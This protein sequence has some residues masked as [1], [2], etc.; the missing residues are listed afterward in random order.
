MLE[1]LTADDS[2]LQKIIFS[3][4]TIF[5]THTHTWSCKLSQLQDLRQ[6]EPI[7]FNPLPPTSV[8]LTSPT[9]SRMLLT[10]VCGTNLRALH[11]KLPYKHVC[12]FFSES[13]YVVL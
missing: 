12:A 6:R 3:D 2:Y 1:Q 4:K 8:Q 13:N 11:L 7:C 10:S 5:H 9:V